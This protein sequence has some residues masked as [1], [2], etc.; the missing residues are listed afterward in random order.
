MAT[1]PD[2][3][4]TD[5]NHIAFYNYKE[6]QGL[7]DSEWDPTDF[8]SSGLVQTFTLYDNGVDGELNFGSISYGDSRDEDPTN[9]TPKFRVKNDGWV[10]IYDDTVSN[11]YGISVTSNSGTISLAGDYNFYGVG[12]GS[13]SGAIDRMGQFISES[14]YT[15]PTSPN[16]NPFGYYSYKHENASN[17][18]SVTGDPM[19]FSYTDSISLYELSVA[20]Q[21]VFGEIG[22]QSCFSAN[23]VDDFT[24]MTVEFVQEL[25]TEVGFTVSTSSNTPHRFRGVDFGIAANAL[26]IWS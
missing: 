23:D 19:E 21:Q 20:T 11:Y 9:Y 15:D 17:I 10:I 1:L 16:N 26:A 24:G 25:G 22:G 5:I 14:G 3:D 6:E 4:P 12:T 13:N 7:T 2:L 18:T 8:T